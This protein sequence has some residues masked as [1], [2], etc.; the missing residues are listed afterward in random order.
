VIDA[1]TGVDCIHSVMVSGIAVHD[2][3]KRRTATDGVWNIRSRPGGARPQVC[4]VIVPNSF[5]YLFI[6]FIPVGCCWV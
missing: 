3:S 4:V 2:P 1:I 5:R 6:A